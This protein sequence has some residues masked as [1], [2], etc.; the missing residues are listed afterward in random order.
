M[1]ARIGD[2]V[3]TQIIHTHV[4]QFNGIER[5]ASVEWI[6]CGMSGFAVELESDAIVGKEDCIQRA[7]ESIGVPGQA[8]I[9]VT[10]YTCSC[11]KGVTSTTFF[12]QATIIADRA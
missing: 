3:L 12:S 10:E 5:T 2:H 8:N 11:H 1:D 4:H 6:S 7:I 9:R